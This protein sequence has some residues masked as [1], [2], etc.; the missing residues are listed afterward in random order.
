M[1]LDSKAGSVKHRSKAGIFVK[2]QYFRLVFP[3]SYLGK[4]QDV[5]A[6]WG[7]VVRSP[8]RQG[9]CTTPVAVAQFAFELEATFLPWLGRNAHFRSIFDFCHILNL[10]RPGYWYCS[11]LAAHLM[12]SYQL[13]LINRYFLY[14]YGSFAG[15]V[16]NRWPN[17]LEILAC[18]LSCYEFEKGG[19][20]RRVSM[21]LVQRSGIWYSNLPVEYDVASASFPNR[22]CTVNTPG[23]ADLRFKKTKP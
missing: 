12:S 7:H 4:L 2:M 16:S 10:A 14:R 1:E 11:D 19:R 18:W 23:E 5:A 8:R 20:F 22:A 15:S 9:P 13:R 3:S 17:F 6:S 21:V